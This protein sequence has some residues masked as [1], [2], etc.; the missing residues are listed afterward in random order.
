MRGY[1]LK[2]FM[3]NGVIQIVLVWL[4]YRDANQATTYKKN[5]ISKCTSYVYCTAKRSFT[6]WYSFLGK[7][8]LSIG[9]GKHQLLYLCFSALYMSNGIKYS[10]PKVGQTQ[11]HMY[12]QAPPSGI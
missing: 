6:M 11:A 12:A 1:Y 7:Q 2:G 5:T 8:I 3:K 4:N 10:W 9:I